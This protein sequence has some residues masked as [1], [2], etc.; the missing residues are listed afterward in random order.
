MNGWHLDSHHMGYR[1]G[2]TPARVTLALMIALAA[3]VAVSLVERGTAHVALLITALVTS[4]VWELVFALVRRR[5][6]GMHMASA[7]L[8]LAVLLPASVP[9]WQVAMAASFGVVFGELVFG[10]RGYGIVSSAAAAAGFLLF[11]F[12]GSEL[13]AGGPTLAIATLPGA[14]LLVVGGLLSW[15]VLVAVT[16]VMIAASV[17]QGDA[18]A[19][20]EALTAVAFG[21]VF[22]V[23]DPVASASTN[24][25]RWIYGA[26]AGVLIM[27]FDNG[28]T[29]FGT[30]SPM[31]VLGAV[32]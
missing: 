7:A 18:G 19:T 24:S 25:G 4:L 28:L 27:L 20:V 6:P 8:I 3:P 26:L 23:G 14:L 1:I 30:G 22:M 11:S 32:P 13:V 29:V 21:V 17:A 15:R 2:W 5:A 9:V 10:G 16:A 12:S 31:N